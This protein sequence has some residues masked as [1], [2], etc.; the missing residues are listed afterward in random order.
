[1]DFSLS[2]SQRD[3]KALAAQILGDILTQERLREIESQPVCHD[4][5]LWEQLAAAGLLGIAVDERFGGSGFDFESLCLLVE[6]AARTVAPAPVIPALVGGALPVGRY[7]SDAQRAE[8]LP[9]L[10]GGEHLLSAALCEPG[11]AE[12]TRPATVAVRAGDG[13]ALS[14]VKHCVPYAEQSRAWVLNAMDAG[15]PGLFLVRAGAEGVEAVAQQVTTGEPQARLSLSS[16]PAERLASGADA[17]AWLAARLT[18][19]WCA[20]AVGLCDKMLRITAEYTSEREQ[21]GVKIATFQ[22]VGQRAADCFIDVEMLTVVTQQAIAALNDED[23]GER[24]DDAGDRVRIAKIWAGDVAHRVS[25][26]AQHLHGGC[27]VDRD[28]ALFRYCLW[29]KQ[30]ELAMGSSGELLDRVGD[31]LAARFSAAAA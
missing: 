10:V 16:A 6:E 5:A 21:F 8:W 7:G 23:A 3:I 4:A 22:A 29:A 13:W 12:P 20:F 15:V 27:G 24:V 1:M 26:A 30:L 2:E 18:A 17:V 25:H 14:G 28:Y 31:D 19:A 9:G 11:N